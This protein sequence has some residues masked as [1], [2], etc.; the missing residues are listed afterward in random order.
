MLFS[1]TLQS[2]LEISAKLAENP[3][4]TRRKTSLSL[5]IQGESLNEAEC[6]NTSVPYFF[7]F[8]HENLKAGRAQPSFFLVKD[9]SLLS[10]SR[11]LKGN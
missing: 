9:S 8:S 11:P 6:I 3:N 4:L 1:S 2:S 10:I 5:V 7:F